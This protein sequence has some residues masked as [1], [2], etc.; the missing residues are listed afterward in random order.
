MC[1]GAKHTARKTFSLQYSLGTNTFKLSL[2]LNRMWT[3][4]TSHPS[5]GSNARQRNHLPSRGLEHNWNTARHCHWWKLHAHLM[6][7][8]PTLSLMEATCSSDE[9]QSNIVTDGSYLL[10]WWNTVQR[11]QCHWWK[12][13]AHLMIHSPTLSRMVAT[14]SSDETWSSIVTDGSY[15]LIW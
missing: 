14:G 13:H 15:L 5:S 6:K 9:T 11:C 2:G 8:S 4:L 3:Q 1:T 10:T 7:Y 12:L